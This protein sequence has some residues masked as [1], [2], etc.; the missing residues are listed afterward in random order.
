MNNLFSHIHRTFWIVNMHVYFATCIIYSQQYVI[1]ITCLKH[2]V[3]AHIFVLSHFSSSNKPPE[4][5]LQHRGRRFP[6]PLSI[7]TF[8]SANN[9]VA[10]TL[11]EGTHHIYRRVQSLLMQSK[12]QLPLHPPLCICIYIYAIIYHI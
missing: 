8:L 2:S 4:G 12:P 11:R 10:I 7:K 1:L 9:K 5:S 6:S 3:M